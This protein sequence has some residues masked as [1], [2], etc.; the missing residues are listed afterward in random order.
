MTSYLVL[1]YAKSTEFGDKEKNNFLNLETPGTM[2]AASFRGNLK[3][4]LV[5]LAMNFY[6]ENNS[7][8]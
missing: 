1:S 7:D 3:K 5:Y 6:G 2:K 8:L 4:K